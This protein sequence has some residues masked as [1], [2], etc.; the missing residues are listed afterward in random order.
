MSPAVQNYQLAKFPPAV[1]SEQIVS[2]FRSPG[3]RMDP[4]YPLGFT[5]TLDSTR[6][7]KTL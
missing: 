4:Q 7:S 2:Y 6:C 5:I 1:G 3:N